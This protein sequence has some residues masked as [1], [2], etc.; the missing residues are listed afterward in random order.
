M[1]KIARTTKR[2]KAAE[3]NLHETIWERM[4][5]Y[6]GRCSMSVAWFATEEEAEKFGAAIRAS[7]AS[8][9]GG[10]FHGMPCGRDRGFDTVKDG[11]KIYAITM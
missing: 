5:E 7:G 11:K 8:Y 4:I 10:W 2:V 1:R 6:S 9:N 3:P